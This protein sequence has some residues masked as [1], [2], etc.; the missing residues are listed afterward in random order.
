MIEPFHRGFL[1]RVLRMSK[2]DVHRKLQAEGFDLL[3]T[4]E[5][6]F[7]PARLV[8]TVGETP[9]ALTKAI[10]P[11]GEFILRCSPALFGLGDYKAI[12]AVR[13]P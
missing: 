6:H 12:S 8:L 9:T 5:L 7:W 2:A 13:T 1:H 11:I 4:R 3:T 10:Y